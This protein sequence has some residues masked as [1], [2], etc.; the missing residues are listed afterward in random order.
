M[1]C[2]SAVVAMTMT[3]MAVAACGPNTSV[4]VTPSAPIAA[5]A[6]SQTPMSA[7]AWNGTWEGAIP[8]G[9]PVRIEIKDGKATRYLFNNRPSRIEQSSISGNR[10][11]VTFAAGATADLTLNSSSAMDFVF[12]GGAGMATA[13]LVKRMPS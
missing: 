9:T 7:E 5:S 3:L 1:K 6:P 4:P 10:M 13:Q 2:K 12:I 11:S 8:N